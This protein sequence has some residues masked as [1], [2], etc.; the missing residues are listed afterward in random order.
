MLPQG[1]CS[2]GLLGI[3]E[4]LLRQRYFGLPRCREGRVNVPG[5]R[6]E[7]GAAAPVFIILSEQQEKEPRMGLFDWLLNRLRAKQPPP[8]APA[9]PALQPPLTPGSVRTPA[10][11]TSAPM[12]PG[13]SASPT[14]VASP[15]AAPSETKPQVTVK[16]FSQPEKKPAKQPNL[17][18]TDFLPISREDLREAANQVNRW[19]PWF[20]IRSVIPPADDPR[21]KLI[22]RGLVT[23]GLLSP[24]QL[25]E[26]HQVG[27][28]MNRL[29]MVYQSINM[30]VAKTGH[31]AVEADRA[32]KAAI[33][34]QK[35][36]E[37]AERKKQRAEGIAHR[38][39]TDILFLGRGVSGQL[40][41]RTSDAEKLGKLSLPV[42][43]TPADVAKALGLSIPKL[44][45]L[46][47]HTE[48]TPRV[49]YVNFSVPKKSGG[50]RLLSAPHRILATAQQWI[51]E[52]ILSK[53]PVES[54]AHG[55]TAGKSILTNAQPHVRKAVVVNMD[56]E[57]FFPNITFPRV[58]SVFHRL[59]YSPAV[60]TILALLCTECPRKQVAYDGKIYHV[61]IGPRGLP[62]GACTSPA[63][64]NQVAR[65]LDKRLSGIATKLGLTYTRYADDLTFSGNDELKGKVG[66]LM[67]RVRHIAQE[68]GFAINEKKSRVLRRNTAQKVTGLVVN[69]K[70]GVSR[71]TVRQIRAI[72]HHARREGL[73]AQNR[74]KHPHFRAWLE[75]MIAY[76]GMVRPDAGVR[77]REQ[78]RS[79]KS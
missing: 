45:W 73:E 15:A 68:D 49:H 35:K 23:Q 29:R 67:A 62:Q 51:L 60:A 20:G 71:K 46:A 72:L 66:Y 4:G 54:P 12:P 18:A 70:P 76:I 55:F 65:R 27:D 3:V 64:S 7:V 63:I 48:V 61:A 56:L 2:F 33:R 52:N 17:S 9:P 5:R 13:E 38:R 39:A 26:M 30:Q 8:P 19:G 57:G 50:T 75:G 25:V 53:L 10:A 47:F 21:T 1:R 78:L 59:G 77:L 58:R 37:S 31:E 22:D 32:R 34:A 41:D 44:R 40:G 42:L 79:C 16:K 28:E 69:D 36:A 43:A 11:A 74:R 14:P 6:L 24:E